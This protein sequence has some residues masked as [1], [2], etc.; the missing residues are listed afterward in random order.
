MLLFGLLATPVFAADEPSTPSDTVMVAGDLAPGTYEWTPERSTAGPV[1][2]VV[3]LPEQTAHVYR[4]GVRIGRSSISSGKTGHDTPPGVYEILEK[5]KVH[6]SN[7]Y[8]NAPMPFM[9]RLTWDGIAL[10]A[11]HIP[12]YPASH[13]CVR[14]PKAFAEQLFQVTE[15]GGMVVVADETTHGEAVLRPGD[16][17][18][19]DPWTGREPGT[20]ADTAIADRGGAGASQALAGK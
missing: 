19:V 5:Q 10:H 3:S 8:N 16:R 13:G 15:R 2:V 7:K 11:G 4:G 12:G 18:P 14:L 20:P 6:H 17:V 9:Q 1:V